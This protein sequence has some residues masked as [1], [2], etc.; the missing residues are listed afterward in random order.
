MPSFVAI[1]IWIVYQVVLGYFS[2]P[3][4]GGVAYAAHIGGFVAGLLLVKPFGYGRVIG[5]GGGWRGRE[6]PPPQYRRG[7]RSGPPGS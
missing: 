5:D 1:G 4:S 6:W 7:D 2:S 3:D